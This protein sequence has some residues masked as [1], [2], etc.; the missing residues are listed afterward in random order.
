MT[1]LCDCIFPSNRRLYERALHN[2]GGD[3]DI[4]MFL[5]ARIEKELK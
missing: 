3:S 1:E 2:N 5:A 4:K